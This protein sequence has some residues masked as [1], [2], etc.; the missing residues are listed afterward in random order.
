MGGTNPTTNNVVVSASMTLNKTLHFTNNNTAGTGSATG[1]LTGAM[2]G[3]GGF[4]KDGSGR[5]S[6]TTVTK[7]YT[8]PT[9]VNQ[10]RLRFTNAG[11]L[12]GT[13]S[14][15]VHNGGLLYLDS[16]GTQTWSFGGGSAVI[17]LNGEG[18]LFAPITGA[19]VLGQ[20]GVQTLTNPITLGSEA[21]ETAIDVDTGGLTGGTLKLSG[22]VS[23]SAKLVKTGN[24]A[25]VLQ[26]AGANTYSGGT[27][28]NSGSIEGQNG[29]ALGSGDVAVSTGAELRFSGTSSYTV[30]NAIQLAG[31]GNSNPGGALNL[32]NTGGTINFTG[33][34][35]LNADTQI[36]SL[37]SATFS[38]TNAITGTDVNLT[39]YDGNAAISG[40]L[41]LGT[42]KLT[43]TGISS[44]AWHLQNA[45]GN[46]YSGGTLIVDGVLE[47]TNTFGSGTGTGDV[48]VG[49]AGQGTNP[50]LNIGNGGASGSITGNIVF[51]DSGPLGTVNF[52]RSDDVAYGGTISG[53]AGRVR[54]LGAGT[55][56]L[57]GNNTYG[58]GSSVLAGTLLVNNTTGSGTG[59]GQVSVF[60]GGALGGTGTI[61]GSVVLIAG[62][63]ILAPGGIPD[64]TLNV[65]DLQLNTGSILNFDL[66]A[67]AASD[68][69]ISA[70]GLTINGGTTLNLSTLS[71]FGVGT[72][73][74]LDYATS[75]TGSFSNLVLATSPPSGFNWQLINNTAN[76]SIDLQVTFP[77]D[78]N[79]DGRVDA[80]DYVFWRK[81]D[82]PQQDYDTWRAHFGQTAGSG[83]ADITSATVPEPLTS[84]MLIVGGVLAICPRRRTSVS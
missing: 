48:T 6:M 55:L 68:K 7:A 59:S 17:T 37:G 53:T 11:Q 34:I 30:A 20:A 46:N 25:G 67:I 36:F 24:S 72:Y 47:V 33:P 14:V 69:V 5:V 77:G 56:T 62:G 16:S 28:I 35:T 50:T 61:S 29:S 51:T 8:G 21:A 58:D 66:G 18:E 57:T 73:T 1:T 84:A 76:T 44:T 12:T 41:S 32:Q 42:G 13:S 4:I 65:G 19:L 2:T 79:N 3:S 78:F 38:N 64:N 15:T 23:G 10:G 26:L 54:K 27:V 75:L 49:V 63:G 81:I 9:T 40:L 83:A 80:A 31:S 71:G 45:A 39:L 60:S 74:L 70:A 43:Q 52:N 82:G 22:V